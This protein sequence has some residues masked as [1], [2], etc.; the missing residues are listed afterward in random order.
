M[1][2]EYFYLSMHYPYCPWLL[3]PVQIIVTVEERLTRVEV[4]G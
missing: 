1:S 4:S 2:R 3:L